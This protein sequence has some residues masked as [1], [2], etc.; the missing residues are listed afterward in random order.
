MDFDFDNDPATGGGEDPME[1]DEEEE[2]HHQEEDGEEDFDNMEDIPVT[3][4]DS[5][6]VIRYASAG[7]QYLHTF[8]AANHC[9]F[10]APTFT[11]KDWFVSN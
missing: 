9:M 1:V 5:W 2:Q 11:R 8:A 7:L 3:Q 10:A 4:E 6:A